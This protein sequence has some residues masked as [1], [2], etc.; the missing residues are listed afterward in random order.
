M[1]VFDLTVVLMEEESIVERVAMVVGIVDAR[2]GRSYISL[3]KE[4]RCCKSR[5]LLCFVTD[6]FA[7]AGCCRLYS[8]R[9]VL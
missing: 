7:P 4:L 8:L 9:I 2:V 1:A 5:R 6:R 3:R